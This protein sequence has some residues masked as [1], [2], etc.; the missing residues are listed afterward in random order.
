MRTK[1]VRRNVDFEAL[2]R[3]I[4]E[5]FKSK[6]FETI[7]EK[8]QGKYKVVGVLRVDKKMRSS[9]VTISQ[10]ADG[11]VVEFIGEKGGRF[12]PLLTPLATMFGGGVFVLDS[13]KSREFYEALETEFWAFMDEAVHQSCIS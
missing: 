10:D 4:A 6:G 7:V 5:F 9:Y 8:S 3:H 13:L 12:L 2:S 11:F 1:W